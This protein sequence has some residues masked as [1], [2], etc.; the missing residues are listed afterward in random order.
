MKINIQNSFIYAHNNRKFFSYY[1]LRIA[2]KHCRR[3][4]PTGKESLLPDKDKFEVGSKVKVRCPAGY[5]ITASYNSVVCE[6][7][8]DA[9]SSIWSAPI[10][11]CS[12]S[13]QMRK[14]TS[15]RLK[16]NQG[17]FTFLQ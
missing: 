12:V 11:S 7:D 1:F 4:T 10:P 15:I 9:L 8:G 3:S 5:G 17:M 13:R 6:Y 2:V 14:F 16:A